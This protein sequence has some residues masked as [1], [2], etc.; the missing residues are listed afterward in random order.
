VNYSNPYI[1]LK[2]AKTSCSPVSTDCQALPF[3]KGDIDPD[4]LGV[5]PYAQAMGLGVPPAYLNP[6]TFQIISAGKDLYFG[7][8]TLICNYPGG[9]P[10]V[11]YWSPDNTPWTPQSASIVYPTSQLGGADD[12]ANFHDRP[13]GVT[14]Q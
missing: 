5:W 7:Q 4:H 10:G 11:T 13:L 6:R 9:Q 8:G 2:P 1:R 12:I 14:T 3:A